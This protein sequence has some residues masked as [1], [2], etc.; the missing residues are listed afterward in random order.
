MPTPLH[1]NSSFCRHKKSASSSQNFSFEQATERSE[2]FARKLACHKQGRGLLYG[3]QGHILGWLAQETESW[4]G[5]K[6]CLV[7]C[8]W[9]WATRASK[10]N[11]LQFSCQPARVCYMK[12][13]SLLSA[14]LPL[15]CDYSPFPDLLAT[16]APPSPNLVP[17]S[18]PLPGIQNVELRSSERGPKHKLGSAAERKTR[19][20]DSFAIRKFT[21]G[22][23]A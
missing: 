11:V 8:K 10:M 21:F 16:F 6:S 20:N 18:V 9:V 17:G 15:V 22:K 12:M 2:H 14:W 3:Q 19:F 13:D 4:G 7:L 23:D 1:P 5:C